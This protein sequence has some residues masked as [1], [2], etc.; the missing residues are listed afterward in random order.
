MCVEAALKAVQ[1]T[2]PEVYESN[3]VSEIPSDSEN[4]KVSSS[5]FEYALMHLTPSNR[6]H[7][8]QYDLVS[9]QKPQTFLY[10]NQGNN[11][12]TQ[13]V[14]PL[15][16]RGIM[17]DASGK[18]V[19]QVLE[20]L[21]IKIEYDPLVHPESFIWRFVC[22]IG[23]SLDGFS[24]HP[25][26]L[27]TLSDESSGL[28][29]SLW[30]GLID[31]KMKGGAF[32]VLFKSFNNLKRSEKKLFLKTIKRFTS[33]LIP[34]EP[35][36]LIFTGRI[37]SKTS[38]FL[39]KFVLNEPSGEQ[40]FDYFNFVIRSIYR[41]FPDDPEIQKLSQNEEEFLKRFRRDRVQAKTV[42]ELERWR[43]EIGDQIRN[44]CKGF[45]LK[46]FDD[47]RDLMDTGNIADCYDEGKGG[48]SEDPE[49]VFF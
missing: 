16:K 28:E 33:T 18:S 19:W 40:I 37:I 45:L 13:V 8:S 11:L 46:Y 5:D 42:L 23:D 43:M 47:S 9:L 3:A 44:D 22:G 26:D 15:L 21:V 34:G 39:K 12:K 2:F 38:S 7:V 35:I 17:K 32:A 6:R 14:D 31:A 1:R 4:I 27:L 10:Q 20:G 41:L 29:A 24:L 25:V 49:E 48:G 30:R 36:I